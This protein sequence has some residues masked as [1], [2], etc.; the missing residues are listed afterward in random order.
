MSA[1][2]Q[3]QVDGNI[4]VQPEEFQRETFNSLY[5]KLATIRRLE[6]AD[7]ERYPPVKSDIQYDITRTLIGAEIAARNTTD[8]LLPE[9]L[10]GISSS[11]LNRTG[12]IPRKSLLVA[13]VAAIGIGAIIDHHATKFRAAE[14]TRNESIKALQVQA[15]GHQR[16]CND[17]Q[18]LLETQRAMNGSILKRLSRAVED[19]RFEAVGRAVSASGIRVTIGEQ[20]V[21]LDV[22]QKLPEKFGQSYILRLKSVLTSEEFASMKEVVEVPAPTFS[23]PRK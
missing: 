15:E 9:I 8:A 3:D 16:A 13:S 1:A 20:H 4:A 19:S 21:T 11:S 5:T 17:L 18:T 22:P 10:S 14:A 12:S 7:P 6:G 23:F 2:N